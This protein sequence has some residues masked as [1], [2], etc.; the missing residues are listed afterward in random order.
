MNMETL[1]SRLASLLKR[2]YLGSRQ[3]PTSSTMSTMIPTPGM[4]HAGNSNFTAAS[5]LDA[6]ANSSNSVQTTPVTSSTL[7]PNGSLPNQTLN[8][9]DGNILVF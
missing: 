9:V 6:T 7:L 4:P 1:H 2:S 8:R 3:P 5:S